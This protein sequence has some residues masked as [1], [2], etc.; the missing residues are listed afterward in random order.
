MERSTTTGTA[1]PKKVA[2]VIAVVVVL[3]AGCDSGQAA[4][5]S[6]TSPVLASTTSAGAPSQSTTTTT[7][8]V[9]TTTTSLHDIP[10]LDPI[11]GYGD[12]SDVP[13]LDIDWNEVVALE[14]QCIQDQGY[15]ATVLPPGN[16]IGLSQEVP[17]DQV[18]MFTAVLYA[19]RAGLQLPPSE[20]PSDEWLAEYYQKQLDTKACLEAEGY[21]ISDPPSLDMFIDVYRSGQPPWTAYQSLRQIS[22]VEWQRLETVCPQPTM[23]PS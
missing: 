10:E 17:P 5:P 13:Y 15:P 11:T 21:S 2:A 23:G 14:V 6:T 18:D 3:V 9:S 8:D 1:V 19:R 12:F 16:G 20:P 4:V 7:G 22:R